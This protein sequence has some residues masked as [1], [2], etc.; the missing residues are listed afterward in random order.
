MT[1]EDISEKLRNQLLSAEPGSE[2][3][4]PEGMYLLSGNFSIPSGVRLAGRGSGMTKLN[5][6]DGTVFL[7]ENVS[8][9]TLQ[10]VS[11]SSTDGHCSVRVRSGSPKEKRSARPVDNIQLLDINID[12]TAPLRNWKKGKHGIDVKA[13]ANENITNVL[14]RDCSVTGAA[15]NGSFEGLDNC[16]VASYDAAGKGQVSD[17]RIENCK[18]SRAGRQNLSVAGKGK[19]KPTRISVINC[20]F[21]DSALAGV[22]LE[23]AS[24]VSIADCTFRGNGLNTQYFTHEKPESS[25]RSGLTVHRT[26]VVVSNC[27][28]DNCFYGYSS[29]NTQGDGVRFENCSFDNAPLDRGS[30]AGMAETAYQN[31]RFSGDRVLVN[32]YNASFSF[33]NCFFTGR[34]A[35]VP[36]M[37]IGGGGLKRRSV[38]K[39]AFNDCTFTGAYGK[40]MEVNY[41]TLEFRECSFSE[42]SHLITVG[43]SN[44]KN[45]LLFDDC[46]FNKI[47]TIGELATGSIDILTIVNSVGTF[48]QSLL[49]SLSSNG[50]FKFSGNELTFPAD[51]SSELKKYESLVFINNTLHSVPDHE[52]SNTIMKKGPF[53]SLGDHSANTLDVRTTKIS[54][55]Q[56]I[57]LQ[58]RISNN[59]E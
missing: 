5:S 23:E 32:F 54:G 42:L 46:T 55:N 27:T 31:C 41:E 28:F 21:F 58:T 45:S 35:G 30:F 20:K 19:S 17:V 52:R 40:L 33:D 47:G 9:V 29:V 43:G 48:D 4:I 53:L 37:I 39:G 7:I 26:D 16:Y 24:A 49:R 1:G 56:V 6:L 36:L 10:G 44:R 34:S 11:L 25:M 59:N 8:N 22:D 38:G 18:F 12:N 50:N 2:I 15:G 14:I 3:L 13:V 57:G 51:G